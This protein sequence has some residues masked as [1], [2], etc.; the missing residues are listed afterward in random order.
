MT[1][2]THGEAAI[3]CCCQGSSVQ[4]ASDPSSLLIE[5]QGE[6]GQD[7]REQGLHV[8]RGVHGGKVTRL[9]KTKVRDGR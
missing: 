3:W 2:G 8:F 6:E 1:H 4:Y 9:K 5:P 7:R